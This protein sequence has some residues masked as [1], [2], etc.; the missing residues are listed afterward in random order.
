MKL[1]VCSGLVLIR[2]YSLTS[3]KCAVNGSKHP[4]EAQ[5]DFIIERPNIKPAYIHG[6]TTDSSLEFDDENTTN[7]D[8][9]S[10]SDC[11]ASDTSTTT[12]S[13]APVP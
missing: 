11:S 8:D 1:L 13:P 10:D 5:L 3:T 6:N 9:E 12:P 7:A 2:Y 4:Y